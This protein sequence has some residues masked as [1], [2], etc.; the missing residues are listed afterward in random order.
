MNKLT[1]KALEESIEHW[2]RMRKEWRNGKETPYGKDCPLC[3][4]FKDCTRGMERCPVFEKTGAT[5]C[6]S[7]PWWDA[8]STFYG[9]SRAHWEA[10]ANREIAFL[11]GLRPATAANEPTATA[12]T[13]TAP[14]TGAGTGTVQGVG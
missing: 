6:E 9:G 11:E 7:T 2:K 13:A 14:A 8:I 10:Q 4:R 5:D 3:R 1:Q 12:P